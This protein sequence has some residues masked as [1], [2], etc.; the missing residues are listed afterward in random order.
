MGTWGQGSISIFAGYGVSKIILF[1]AKSQGIPE[2][3]GISRCNFLK[4]IHYSFKVTATGCPCEP[5]V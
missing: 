4:N 2:L 3:E 1:N 5:R